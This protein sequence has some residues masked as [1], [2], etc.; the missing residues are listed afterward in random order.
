L[1]L[2][3][4]ARR[5]VA[6]DERTHLAAPLLER[7]DRAGE[8]VEPLFLDEAAE[9]EEHGFVPGE[10]LRAPPGLAAPRR[11]EL[12]AVDAAAPDPQFVLG[13]AELD[14]ALGHRRIG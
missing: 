5:P 8:D 7:P 2:E 13:N 10:A 11:A 14:E 6:D 9:E 1:R 4:R 3:L 12:L